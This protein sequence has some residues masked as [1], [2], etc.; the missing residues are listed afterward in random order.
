MT[1]KVWFRREKF[2][3]VL[4]DQIRDYTSLGGNFFYGLVFVMLFG[5]GYFKKIQPFIQAARIL[6]VA[7]ILFTLIGFAVKYVFR[8]TRPDQTSLK[9]AS[10]LEKMNDASFPSI[11]S[12]RVVILAYVVGSIVPPYVREF[13]WVV[14]LGVIGTRIFL[15]K[16]YWSDVIAGALL[17]FLITYGVA[18]IV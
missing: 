13:V 9:G 1:K 3:A 8:R 12:G 7:G 11:H 15:K 10:I 2:Q 14:M 16:H 17:G 5:I 4:E 6:L 18:L